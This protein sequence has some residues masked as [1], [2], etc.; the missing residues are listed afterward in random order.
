MK[1][2]ILNRKSLCSVETEEE[3]H[4]F[5]QRNGWA[6]WDCI[7]HRFTCVPGLVGPEERKPQPGLVGEREGG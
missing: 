2:I 4:S 3:P 6:P 1:H 7:F 5:C